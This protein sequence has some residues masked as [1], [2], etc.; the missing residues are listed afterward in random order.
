MPKEISWTQVQEEPYRLFFPLGILIAMIGVGH[1][2]AYAFGWTAQCSAFFHSSIQTQV[3]MTCF[4]VGFLMTAMPKFT[5]SL[6]ATASEVLRFLALILGDTISLCLGKWIAAEL[7]FAGALISL[8]YFAKKRIASRSQS[9]LPPPEFIWIPIGIVHGLTGTILMI[10]IQLKRAPLAW[11]QASKLMSEQGFISCVVM[12]VGGFLAP[13]LM[14]TFRA[15]AKPGQSPQDPG[16]IKIRRKILFFHLLAGTIF[17]SSFWLGLRNLQLSYL[18]RAFIITIEY[19]WT[20]TYLKPP[21]NPDFYVKLIWISL[22]MVI[23]GSWSV[24]LLPQY[25]TAMLHLIFIGG[26]SLMI[27]SVATMVVLSH[28]GEPEKIG[29]PLAILWSSGIGVAGSLA[30]RIAAAFFPEKYFIFLGLAGIFWTITAGLWFFFALPKILKP[31]SSVE[32]AQC[33]EDSKQRI[34]K[35]RGQSVPAALPKEKCC[36]HKAACE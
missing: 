15:H 24:A 31:M 11:F 9:I 36:D 23:L 1:W 20:C 8:L 18:L 12:G 5:S 26:F 4:V 2:P 30:C 16:L 35:L 33:H 25:R 29:R 32:L 10:L 19:L 17:F 27:F 21:K 7:C 28:G 13:R 6:R 22:W 14:G 3:Y 34:A